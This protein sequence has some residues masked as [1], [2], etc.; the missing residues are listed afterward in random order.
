MKCQSVA[1]AKELL[2]VLEN[3]HRVRW[4]AL[5]LGKHAEV[6]R[7]R[8]H[9]ASLNRDRK[10]QLLVF[11]AGVR[12]ARGQKV[13]RET[14]ARDRATRA[15]SALFSTLAGR[16]DSREAG[17]PKGKSTENNSSIRKVAAYETG[18]TSSIDRILQKFSPRSGGVLRSVA[19]RHHRKVTLSVDVAAAGKTSD[20]PELGE[21]E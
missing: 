9:R 18:T 19:D 15:S 8:L 1:E 13:E 14:S 2:D 17:D 5:L 3:T 4:D 10:H 11:S 16:S 12:Q 7:I 21:C 20:T 6:E